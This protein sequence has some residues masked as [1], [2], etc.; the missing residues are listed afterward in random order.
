MDAT[1]TNPISLVFSFNE[2]EG[3]AT[4][5]YL[6]A[7]LN[8]EKRASIFNHWICTFKLISNKSLQILSK[9]EGIG[10]SNKR[11]ELDVINTNDSQEYIHIRQKEIHMTVNGSWSSEEL[12][13]LIDGF[14]N[15]VNTYTNTLYCKCHQK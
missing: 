12:Q 4:W 6:V 11:I 1:N 5:Y 7:S 3:L 13:D 15:V 10:L 2:L 8:N 9:C 14:I